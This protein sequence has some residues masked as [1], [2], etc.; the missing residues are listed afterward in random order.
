MRILVESLIILI[1]TGVISLIV[2][3]VKIWIRHTIIIVLSIFVIRIITRLVLILIW[4]P[5]V[6]IIWTILIGGAIT[7]LSIVATIVP[8]LLSL[9]IVAMSRGCISVVIGPP[10]CRLF[11]IATTIHRGRPRPLSGIVVALARFWRTA[12]ATVARIQTVDRTKRVWRNS[13]VIIV[14]LVV[15]SSFSL[16][17]VYQTVGNSQRSRSLIRWVF[18]RTRSGGVAKVHSL[19]QCSKCKRVN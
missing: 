18:S 16:A 13:F 9:P 10:G 8:R 15:D 17:T 7:L 5:V 1:P 14:N 6:W 11:K 3:E 4:I 12:I 19:N 2:L